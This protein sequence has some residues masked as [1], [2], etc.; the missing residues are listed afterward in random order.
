MSPVVTVASRA[1]SGNE[2]LRS[3]L[4][5]I[6]PRAKF[7]ENGEAF[8]EEELVNFLNGAEG[9]IVG[10]EPITGRVLSGCPGL[11][12]VAKFGVGLDNVDQAACK[13][14]GIRIGWTGGVNRRCV[15]ELTLG[16]MLAAGHNMFKTAGE[17]RTGTWEKDGGHLLSG[18]TVGIIGVGHVG[19]DLIRL[20]QPFDCR[21]LAND[22]VDQSN[23]YRDAGVEDV[24]KEQIFSE[25]DYVTVH[26]PLTED[27]RNM[28]DAAALSSMK[29]TAHL[30]NAARGGIIDEEAL[31]QALVEGQIASASLDVFVEEPCTD[32]ELL[33]L[34]NL[35]ATPHI[36]G[37]AVES[38]LAM[39]RS[40]ISHLQKHF[41]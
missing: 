26:T 32:L 20:L 9:A 1:F 16:F 37:N 41:G 24:T 6:F 40:A 15:S 36:A 25:A 2:T 17:M 19:K 7:N 29:P 10:I 3:E 8:A 11:Q 21:I 33:G 35:F 31:K 30:I 18:R 39:G 28:I 4:L 12:I 38:V 27:T 34:P 14:Q 23:Y 13:E 5:A 22:I